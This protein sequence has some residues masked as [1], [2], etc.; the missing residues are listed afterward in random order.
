MD[1]FNYLLHKE[2]GT[3]WELLYSCKAAVLENL[4]K[5]K[6][7]EEALKLG[8]NREA[9]PLDKM[10]N[11][12]KRFLER[13]A[14]RVAKAKQAKADRELVK[15]SAD[16]SKSKPSSRSA[17]SRS[18]QSARPEPRRR[19]LGTLAGKKTIPLSTSAEAVD[20]G[21]TATAL[22]VGPDADPTDEKA[23]DAVEWSHFPTEEDRTKENTAAKEAWAGKTLPQ[24]RKPPRK[25]PVESFDIFVE[26]DSDSSGSSSGMSECSSASGKDEVPESDDD[27]LEMIR[28][29]KE[30]DLA[31][32]RQAALAAPS[33]DGTSF[34]V[35]ED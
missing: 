16:S 27:I 14:L 32:Q 29:M 3:E 11:N 25:Q 7:A 28:R 4:G 30:Q 31:K 35:F 19:A 24:K 18:S 15:G 34:A 22:A 5:Y 2:I 9:K 6:E 13:M 23:G 1:V 8:V 12:H 17:S 21:S 10:E 26:E 20:N 33:N